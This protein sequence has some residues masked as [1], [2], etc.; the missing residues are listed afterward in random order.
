MF[1]LGAGWAN[2]PVLNLLMEHYPAIIVV[3]GTSDEA[4]ISSFLDADIVVTNGSSVPRETIEY[5][6]KASEH[7]DIVVLTDPDSPGKRIRD[8]LDQ[9]IEGLQHAFVL[10]EH[11][12]KHHKV[13]VAESSKEDV[14]MALSHLVPSKNNRRGNLVMSDLFDLGLM[15]SWVK[16]L[17]PKLKNS[18]SLAISSAVSAARGISI[19]IDTAGTLCGAAKAIKEIG[20]KSVVAC[21]THAVLSGPAIERI[22][23]SV[24]DEVVLLD[25]IRLS[26]EKRIDK[27]KTIS[28]A[29]VLAEAIARIYSDKPVSTLFV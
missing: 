9:N 26:E 24:L 15:V 6:K 11:A 4:F 19:M 8:I 14:L 5:L 3:E 23:N 17:V 2:V 1:G 13:G 12:I 10:K 21:A 28:V 22:Q 29:P 27:I 20:A 16:S 7:R 25:T 18:A